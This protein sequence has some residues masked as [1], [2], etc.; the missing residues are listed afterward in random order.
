MVLPQNEALMS[1]T[2]Y[3]DLQC[4]VKHSYKIEPQPYFD[5]YN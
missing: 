5:L 1:C 3:S 2:A 4:D